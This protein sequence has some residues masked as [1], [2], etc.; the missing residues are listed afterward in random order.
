MEK[1]MQQSI[2]FL[3]CNIETVGTREDQE[4]GA[5]LSLFIENADT[6]INGALWRPRMT[7][8]K[9]PIYKTITMVYASC[10]W[11]DLAVT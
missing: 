5:I 11:L 3:P 6:A 10:P 4:A 9:V 7:P 2:C 8:A 1:Q